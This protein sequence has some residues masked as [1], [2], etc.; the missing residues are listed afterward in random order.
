M[1]NIVELTFFLCNVHEKG[2]YSWIG[3]KD[4]I[5]QFLLIHWTAQLYALDE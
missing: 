5:T 3:V 2:S 1:L 4:T